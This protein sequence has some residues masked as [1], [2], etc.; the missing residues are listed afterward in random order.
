MNQWYHFKRQ[1]L[2]IKQQ[3]AGKNVN[4]KKENQESLAC[5]WH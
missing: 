5:F 3:E 2:L 4:R 1:G